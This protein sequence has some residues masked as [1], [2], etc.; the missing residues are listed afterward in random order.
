MSL[1]TQQ[2]EEYRTKSQIDDAVFEYINTSLEGQSS[3]E[4]YIRLKQAEYF[5]K[6]ALEMT[7]SPAINDFS[8]TDLPANILHEVK[9]VSTEKFLYSGAIDVMKARQKLELKIA[10]EKEQVEGI[11][12][13]QE[14]EKQIRVTLKK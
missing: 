9:V 4:L 13:K 3:V 12:K 10:Q 1:I 6:Q 7:S 2:F 11:A 5:V 14:A 8:E